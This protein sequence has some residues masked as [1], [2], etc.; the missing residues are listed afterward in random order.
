[1]KCIDLE[2]RFPLHKIGYDD[3]DVT[4]SR[5]PWNKVIVCGA[6]HICPSGEDKL[7][8]CTD[9]RKSK[10]TREILSGKFPCVVK[11]DG[12][13]GVSAEFNVKDAKV[14]LNLMKAKKR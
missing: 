6:G 1:M 13:D 11:Q 10:A 3:A 4:G 2:A 5:D 9:S 8:A 12:D 14:F 7:W